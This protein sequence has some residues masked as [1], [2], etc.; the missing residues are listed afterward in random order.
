[1]YVAS[2]LK[3]PLNKPAH[4]AIHQG[5]GTPN[6]RTFCPKEDWLAIKVPVRNL[7]ASG[8]RGMI[9]IGFN[10]RYRFAPLKGGSA[11]LSSELWRWNR[12]FHCH[13]GRAGSAALDW[14]SVLDS[15]AL[16][17]TAGLRASLRSPGMTIA[18]EGGPPTIRRLSAQSRTHRP[19]STPILSTPCAP[20]PVFSPLSAH[21]R[22]R[23]LQTPPP[24]YGAEIMKKT[25]RKP[26]ALDRVTR[27]I[28]TVERLALRARVVLDMPTGTPAPDAAPDTVMAEID[29]AVAALKRDPAGR[30]R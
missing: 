1:M 18:G 4:I 5:F 20:R 27:R 10:R 7:P 22:S 30:A 26:D 24:Q 3:L 15:F 17:R 25:P 16:A 11:M 19:L 6:S 21:H 9:R 8:C 28:E 14:P 2:A 23:P 12:L 29:R 13:C